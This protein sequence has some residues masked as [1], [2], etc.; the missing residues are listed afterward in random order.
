[1]QAPGGMRAAIAL[2]QRKP[3]SFQKDH[4]RIVQAVASKLATI[5]E[6]AITVQAIQR[7]SVTDFVTGLPNTRALFVHLDR[8]IAR[9]QRDH[10]DLA[11][12]SCDLNGFKR[13]NDQH[14]HLEGNR[15]LVQVALEFRSVCRAYDCVARMGGD[16]F[17]LVLPGLGGR[18]LE[19]RLQDFREAVGRVGRES[20]SAAHLTVSMG[21][22]LFPHHGTTAEELLAYADQQMYRQKF[23]HY[24]GTEAGSQTRLE[25]VLR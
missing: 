7:D 24:A 3:D 12:V 18:E 23:R 2:Y 6:N 5:V 10:G 19:P 11:V 15:I 20:P 14:G 9:A 4:Q 1:M 17:V 8:E 22:A 16:E 25:Y 13:I 21:A